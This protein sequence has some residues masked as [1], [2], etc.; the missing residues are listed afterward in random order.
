VPAHDRL[1]ALISHLQSDMNSAAG[2]RALLHYLRQRSGAQLAALFLFNEA[3]H[4]LALLDQSGQRPPLV[5][6][7]VNATGRRLSPKYLPLNGLF[8]SVLNTSGLI[9]IPDLYLDPRTLPQEQRWGWPGGQ[10]FL[11]AVKTSNG[12]ES[13]QGVAVLSF[14]EGAQAQTAQEDA[15]QESDIL[16]GIILLSLYLSDLPGQWDLSLPEPRFPVSPFSPTAPAPIA[17]EPKKTRPA[18]RPRRKTPA[19]T[20][21]SRR[22]RARAATPQP[23]SLSQSG[24]IEQA[25][26]FSVLLEEAIHQERQRIARDLH[27]GPAQQL[28]HVLHKLEF[29]QNAYEKYQPS[30]SATPSPSQRMILSELRQSRHMLATSIED[31]RAIIFSPIPQAIETRGFPA[32]IQSLIEDQR[33]LQPTLRIDYRI[34]DFA[35]VPSSLELPVFRL[36]QETLN[37]IVKHAQASVV[38]LRIQRT[39]TQLVVELSDDGTGMTIGENRQDG[40]KRGNDVKGRSKEGSESGRRQPQDTQLGL[41]SMRE[42]IRQAGGS[43]EIKS[44]PG[45]GTTII[46]HFPLTMPSLALTSRE[47]EVLLLVVDGLT[48]RAIAERLSISVET[49]KSHLHHIMQKMQ[50]KDRT[51]AAVAATRQGLL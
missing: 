4:E 50:V 5:T 2:R 40:G 32:A 38:T 51:Q 43:W 21:K 20:P 1:L 35:L 42:R 8:G 18:R 11:S 24:T 10:L 3:R 14:S 41:R 12:A 48:N 9:H 13:K 30:V 39:S 36:I 29:I 15:D 22:T 6:G 45:R 46:A 44:K 49:V 31:L 17:P 27:D 47:H 28:A 25:K 16:V 7:T 37:N 34:D 33:T 19:R 26:I 23:S